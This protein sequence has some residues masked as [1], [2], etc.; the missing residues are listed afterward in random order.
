MELPS[1]E[2][3]EFQAHED[4][5]RF[6]WLAR[7][8]GRLMAGYVSLVA[9]TA[10][11]SGP[12]ISQ[13]QVILAI[14]HEANLA[15]A[16]AFYRLRDDK[17][18]VVFSTRGFRGI[19]VNTLLASLGASVVTLPDEGTETRAEAAALARTMAR[20]GRSGRSLVVSCDGPWG[21]HRVA[22]PG[23][24]MVARE[25]GLPIQPWA[26][27][28]RPTR[29]LRGRWDRQ[30]V[31]LPFGRIRV[32]QGTRLEVGPRQRIKPL[33]GVLQE[34]LEQVARTAD[35]RMGEVPTSRQR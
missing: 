6:A 8:T 14:W 2:P 9:R 23:V 7:L 15:T 18:P 11:F 20:I 32:V 13:D 17:S 30:I 12:R 3:T 1:V 28:V 19:V 10:R 21:P 33:L 34:E 26:I 29:R 5:V 16:V 4:P 22:K 31:P 25:S 35:R 24:L 27:S